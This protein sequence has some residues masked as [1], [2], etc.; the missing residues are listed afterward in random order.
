VRLRTRSSA[1]WTAVLLLV[2][3]ELTAS[4]GPH[5]LR[6]LRL[7]SRVR[8]KPNYSLNWPAGIASR[9]GLASTPAAS[10]FRR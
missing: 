10:Y 5:P 2:A 6:A 7:P 3:P 4:S 9:L 8:S 1:T